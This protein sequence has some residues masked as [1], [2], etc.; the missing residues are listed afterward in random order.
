LIWPAR[1][2]RSWKGGSWSCA[3]LRPLGFTTFLE[4]RSARWSSSSA[5]G[6][7]RNRET[8]YQPLEDEAHIR[9]AVRWV[10]ARPK[11]FL[12]SVGDVALLPLV[13][14]AADLL[15]PMPDDAAMARLD[16]RAGLTSIFGL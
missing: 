5:S 6:A 8:W 14:Q 1:R 11:F 2:S 10:L 4:R 13:L 15:G 7:A 9:A 3:S 16:E 12:T